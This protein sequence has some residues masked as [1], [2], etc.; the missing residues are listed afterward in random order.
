MSMIS[1]FLPL[2]V[3]FEG[4]RRQRPCPKQCEVF[5]VFLRVCPTP[6]GEEGGLSDFLG[7]WVSDCPPPPL[8]PQGRPLWGTLGQR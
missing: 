3:S 5:R 6:P 4:A 8:P 2:L 7:G 1:P